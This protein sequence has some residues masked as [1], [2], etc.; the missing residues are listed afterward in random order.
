MDKDKF[1]LITGA[2]PA[3]NGYGKAKATRDRARA[4]PINTYLGNLS[5]IKNER[6]YIVRA[7][8]SSRIRPQAQEKLNMGERTLIDRINKHQIM[9]LEIPVAIL[10]YQ[11]SLAKAR[12]KK[13]VKIH[14]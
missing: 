1:I 9:Q 13:T 8:N 14:I 2:R 12:G 6:D 11:L 7:L 3:V 4:Y 10:E 5:L